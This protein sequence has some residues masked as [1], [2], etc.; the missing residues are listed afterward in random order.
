[1]KY[2]FINFKVWYFFVNF[3]KEEWKIIKLFYEEVK[4][5]VCFFFG[6]IIVIRLVFVFLGGIFWYKFNCCMYVFCLI[7]LIIIIVDNKFI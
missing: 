6:R 1:M 7:M 2:I 3:F 4:K 5:K